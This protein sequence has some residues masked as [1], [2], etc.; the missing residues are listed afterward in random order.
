MSRR[1][2]DWNP[3]CKVYVGGLRSDANKYDIEDAFSEFGKVV[4]VWVA[5]R[6]PGFGF[7][8]FEDPRD[9]KD[10]VKALDGE[11]ICGYRVKV[12]MCTGD[13]RNKRSRRSRTR[14]RSRSE[15]R[16]RR[17]RSR[18]RD[19]KRGE[20]SRSRRRRRS[21][22][23]GSGRRGRSWTR[24]GRS[25]TRRGRSWTRPGSWMKCHRQSI[26]RFSYVHHVI[27][28]SI[29]LCFPLHVK[30]IT[31]LHWTSSVYQLF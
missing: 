17:D 26:N 7:V 1:H 4:N 2:E 30:I 25:C 29:T 9:A 28:P 5:Q 18:S 14:S 13:F 27:L 10:A 21:G 19:R 6:P 3:D 8:L 12:E 22:S 31:F 23:R 15:G 24:R 16:S 11:K 20:R